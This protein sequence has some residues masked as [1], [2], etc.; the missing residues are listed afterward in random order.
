MSV[1]VHVAVE[2]DLPFSPTTYIS[3]SFQDDEHYLREA[4]P[5]NPYYD[6]KQALSKFFGV[7]VASVWTR[8][9]EPLG[10]KQAN[11]TIN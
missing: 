7:Q 9:T 2:L 1:L 6:V 10:D 5:P 3:L 11:F 8:W 4:S